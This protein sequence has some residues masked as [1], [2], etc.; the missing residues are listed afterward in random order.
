M[1]V[2]YSGLAPEK[3]W[4]SAAVY[5]FLGIMFLFVAWLILWWHSFSNTQTRIAWVPSAQAPERRPWFWTIT[6]M[7]YPPMIHSRGLFNDTRRGDDGI[8]SAGAKFGLIAKGQT[9]ESIVISS[10]PSD[11]QLCKRSTMSAVFSSRRVH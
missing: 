10:G 5:A 9:H 8:Q 1:Q 11:Q 6:A 3:E 2:Y 7:D 4:S